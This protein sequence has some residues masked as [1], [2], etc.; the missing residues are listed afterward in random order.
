MSWTD[1][2]LAKRLGLKLH[3][4]HVADAIDRGEIDL[5]FGELVDFEN[6]PERRTKEQRQET[7]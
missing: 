3:E 6:G 4:P 1:Q 5:D 7:K 2:V